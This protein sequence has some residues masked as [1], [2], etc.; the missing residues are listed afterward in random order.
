MGFVKEGISRPDA[1]SKKP[2][3]NW[4]AQDK[5]RHLI[6]SMIT[7]IF[8]GKVTQQT[9]N[10]TKEKSQL[11]GGG[12]TLTL[13]IVKEIS[14]SRNPQNRFSVKDILA[15]VAGITLGILLLGAT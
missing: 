11:I 6:G 14:D 12:I 8:I 1:I 15:D 2:A 4:W 9:L 13:G 10:Y 7:T 5:G 3:D